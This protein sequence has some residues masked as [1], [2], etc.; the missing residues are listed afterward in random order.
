MTT[1]P[2]ACRFCNAPLSR[3]FLDLGAQPLANS[4]VDA[5]AGL[6]AMEP[7]Y[8][9]HVRVCERCFLV[10]LPELATAEQIFKEYAYLSS[11]SSSWLEHCRRFVGQA[12][13]RF[14]LGPNDLVVEVAS[15]DGYLLRY[16]VERGQPVLGIEPAANVAAI[17]ER[18]GVPTLTRFFGT[19]CADDLVREGKLAKLLVGNNVLAH[20][21]DINDFVEGLRRLLA[22]GGV[23][24]MEF[25]HLLELM[26]F[27]QFDTIYHEHF[28]YLSLGTVSRVF[29]AHRLTI[30]D[31]QKLPTHGG[32]LRVFA[33]RDDDGGRS[34]EPSVGRVLADEGAAGFAELA[35]YLGFTE[36][37]QRTKWALLELLI[38][39]R[40]DGKRVVG[41]GAPAKGNTLL[42]YCGVRTD[43]LAYSVDRNPLKQGH[44]LPGT[45][46]PVRAPEAILEDKPEFVL[47]LPWNIQAEIVEQMAAVREWGG[48]FI[49]P[50]PEPRV[51]P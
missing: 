26:R 24:S 29:T 33:C 31:V 17:A 14:S 35:T 50:I 18:E 7:F 38:K 10:Q 2:L 40:R 5:S 23:L 43:L 16:F 39:L 8:P 47:I 12:M 45:R 49:V 36:R 21:P 19:K 27:N 25:P 6:T 22:P 51:L 11:T 48:Q 32:S 44:L 28:S 4:Y 13:E 20:V 15:N 46:I 30:F 9:L 42:N 3:T 41:Y 34:I 1:A 37:V